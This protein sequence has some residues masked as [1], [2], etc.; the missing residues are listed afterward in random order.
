MRIE[1]PQVSGKPVMKGGTG[2]GAVADSLNAGDRIKSEVLSNKEGVVT[3]KTETGQIFKARL[4][5]DTPLAAGDKVLLEVMLKDNGAVSLTVSGKYGQSDEAPGAAQGQT[6]VAAE[7]PD[8]GL[9][10]YTAKLAELRLPVT[11]ESANM[12]RELISRNPGMSLEDAAFIAANKLGNSADMIKA[13][14]ALLGGGE[15]T[16]AMVEKLLNLLDQPGGT[17]AAG[18]KPPGGP[19]PL[20]NTQSGASAI[21]QNLSDLPQ[22]GAS[23]QTG[24]PVNGA[25]TQG[26]PDSPLTDLLRLVMN[27][28]AAMQNGVSQGAPQGVS[29]GINAPSPLADQIITQPNGDMQS[30]ISE[31]P[32]VISQNNVNTPVHAG[33][34]QV[35]TVPPQGQPGVITQPEAGAQSAGNTLAG[36]AE[37]PAAQG[38][39]VISGATG[40]AGIAGDAQGAA[41]L[42]GAVTA[43]DAQ[44]AQAAG[45]AQNAQSAPGAAAPDAPPAPDTGSA[46]NTQTAQT[47]QESGTA[48]NVPNTQG[49][50]TAQTAQTAQAAAGGGAAQAA[51]GGGAAAAQNAPA[52]Q[53]AQVPNMQP[54]Q[55]TAQ[56]A[57]VSQDA[58]TP[59][60]QVSAQAASQPPPAEVSQNPAHTGQTAGQP[61]EPGGVTAQNQQD[62]SPAKVLA[63]ALSELPEFRS[64]PETALEKFSNMFYR[65][66]QDSADIERNDTGKLKNLLET[67]FTQIE[68][69]SQNT[70]E[71][72]KAARE[73][74]FARLSFLEEAVTRAA[75][76][77]K[78][79]MLEQTGKLLDH[80]RVQGNID[81]YYYMQIPVMVGD[82]RNTAELYMFK[83]KGGKKP[84][85]DNVN[86]LLAIELEHLGHWE[87]LI[88]FKKKDVSIQMEVPGEAEKS[89]L[90]EN[91][92]LLHQMLAEA[93]FKLVNVDIKY[94]EKETN[95]VNALTSLDR[96]MS[97]RARALDFFI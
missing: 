21:I 45:A 50:D 24:A 93:G 34:G 40:M 77:A 29:E 49:A 15:K 92:V 95:P 38:A 61:A 62:F 75:P 53:S 9:E 7:S 79:A 85:P 46:R 1:I 72:L 25:S 2:Q 78:A 52:E 4:E 54:A 36:T 90:S 58:L 18:A 23:A 26:L 67:L 66:A 94:T 30:T 57:R 14:Q 47:T 3:L 87:S 6:G 12:M 88:N 83:R 69:D 39:A 32:E 8:K 48:Q 63:R 27:S 43:Q 80:V 96:Y 64:T 55:E 70:G 35:N 51:A 97:G 89:H 20:I 91:T 41:G 60:P 42:L 5:T 86:I 82:E 44:S 13:A 84:D 28:V 10:P 19:V 65:V 17:A 76:H 59:N 11:A 56:T 73:E 81:Q 74:M 16:D 68:R 71:K 33:S 37:T 22:Q 31:N